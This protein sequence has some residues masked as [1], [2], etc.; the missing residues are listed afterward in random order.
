MSLP[1][2]SPEKESGVVGDQYKAKKPTD[3]KEIPLNRLPRLR[4]QAGP[5]TT[6]PPLPKNPP[7][8][9]LQ[10]YLKYQIPSQL[11]RS[12]PASNKK[13]S[14]RNSRRIRK[15][16]S[17]PDIRLMPPTDPRSYGI[18]K[19]AASAVD[20]LDLSYVSSRR[21]SESCIRRWASEPPGEGQSPTLLKFTVVLSP[22]YPPISPPREF[23]DS[24][25]YTRFFTPKTVQDFAEKTRRASLSSPPTSAS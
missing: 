23:Y 5:G 25:G 17:C 10:E 14:K 20:D 2:M 7:R 19:S 9:L 16:D 13:L 22:G 12:R 15:A 18:P 3:G 6:R 8:N 24:T 1:S 21:M 11:P 4:G